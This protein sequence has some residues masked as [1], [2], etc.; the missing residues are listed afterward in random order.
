MYL[1][2]ERLATANQAVRETFANTCI[3]WQAIPHWDTG[4]PAQTQVPSDV[5]DN[6]T[7]LPLEPVPTD[8]TFEVTLAQ[9]CAPTPDGLLAE[10]IKATGDLAKQVD[11]VVLQKLSDDAT[12][13]ADQLAAGDTLQVIVNKLIEARAQLEDE[14]YRAPSCLFTNT[15]G[16]IAFSELVSGYPSTESVLM[17]ANANSLYRATTVDSG[18][19]AGKIIVLLLGRRQR[20]AQ[21]T[22]CDATPG[23]EPVDIAFSVLPGL[24][25]LG[26]TATGTIELALRIRFATRVKDVK[27]IVALQ[28]P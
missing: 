18:V 23:E 19:P 11:T 14:G 26:E 10:V 22:A 4:D 7:F 21:G 24:E 16:L 9:A 13:A 8:V 12:V 2:A 28:E 27:G 1:S 15:K 20:I 17:A 5:V 25:V 3:A 6:P